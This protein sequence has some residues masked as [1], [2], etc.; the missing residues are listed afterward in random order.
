[1]VSAKSSFI[2]DTNRAKIFELTDN[3]IATFKLTM[4]DEQFALLKE[5]CQFVGGNF[6]EQLKELFNNPPPMIPANNT[7]AEAGP[8]P[9]EEEEA[10]KT[11]DATLVVQ[12]NG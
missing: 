5:N 10:F 2:G 1:M 7:E 8:G 11:K 12:V 9:A 6:V 4:P 3:E